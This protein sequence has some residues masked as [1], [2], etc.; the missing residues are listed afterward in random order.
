[1]SEQAMLDSLRDI[2]L[3][4]G[5]AGGALAEVAAVVALAALAALAIAGVLRLL[6]VRQRRQ[7]PT[8]LADE[9]AALSGNAVPDRRSALL[10]MLRTHAPDRYAALRHQLY[11]P[12][13]G[14]ETA[15][16]EAEV[17]RLV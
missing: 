3:P 11:R 16:L 12:D 9:L 15:V 7:V 5:A 1:M 17:S 14:L 6:S 10:H 8:G 4:E 2:H 13:S